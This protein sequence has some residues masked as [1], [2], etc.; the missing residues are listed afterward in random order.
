[1]MASR[2]TSS[3][4]FDPDTEKASN[5]LNELSLLEFPP[6]CQVRVNHARAAIL[7]VVVVAL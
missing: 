6:V 2:S 4:A 1:M 3:K 7:F 5:N